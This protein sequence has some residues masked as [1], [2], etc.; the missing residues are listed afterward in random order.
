MYIKIKRDGLVLHGK[1]EKKAEGK[2]PVVIMFHGFGGDIDDRPNSVYQMLSDKLNDRGVATIRFDFNGHGKSGGNFTDMNL[3]NELCDAIAII[4][5]VKELQWVEEIYILG[6]SQGGVVGGMLAGYYADVVSK[7]VLLA[8]AASL[9]TDAQNG[10]C[11]RAIYDANNTPKSVNV[12][13]KHK[14][15]GHFFR[16]AKTLPI[17]EVTAQF[18]K[19]TLIVLGD[20]DY[21][22]NAGEAMKYKRKMKKC[23][24]EVMEGLDHGLCGATQNIMFE[25]VVDFIRSR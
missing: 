23:Q 5:Y 17:H 19:D 1:L 2:A 21:V 22:I 14:V 10:I 11:M 4:E 24:I 15:G 8:P 3:F 18:N 13:G 25:K 16:I 12:D 20:R 7:L 9:K 6:H